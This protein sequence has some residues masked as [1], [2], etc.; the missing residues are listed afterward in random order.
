MRAPGGGVA[1]RISLSH[2]LGV[3]MPPQPA[4]IGRY[5]VLREL[6]RGTMGVVYEA[7]DPILG[8]N[9]ALKVIEIAFGVGEDERHTFERRFFAEARSAARLSHPGIVVVHD[10]GR[11]Q[12]SG[13]LFMALELIEGD[14]VGSVLK[15]RGPFAWQEALRIVARVAE[16]L[17]HAHA[18]GV[19]HRDVKPTNLMLLAPGGEPKVMDFGIAKL[20]TSQ[21]TAA[22]ELLGTPL[23]MSPEQA[24]A[25]PL[26]GRSD[27][28]SLGAVLYEMLTGRRAFAGESVTKIL[29]NVMSLEP[30]APS[31]LATGVP[32]SVDYILARSLSKEAARRYPDGRS[33]AEDIDDVLGGRTPRWRASWP[34]RTGSGTM[35]AAAPSART[36]LAAA[37]GSAHSLPRPPAP[38]GDRIKGLAGRLPRGKRLQAAVGA[39]AVVVLIGG[40]LILRST[41]PSFVARRLEEDSPAAPGGVPDSSPAPSS[42]TG[43]AAESGGMD[44]RSSARLFVDFE[45]SLKGGVLRVWVDDQ[46]IIEEPFGGRITRRIGGIELRKGHLSEGLEVVPG[47]R[48][49]RVQVTWDDNVKT[50][51]TWATF[52]AGDT[53]RLKA[54]LGSLAGLRKD[55]SLDWY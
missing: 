19:V 25:R 46:P 50:E 7:H 8:R 29:F 12:E 6:G 51:R 18:H 17:H 13:A 27:L 34:P 55:L 10:V 24:L 44:S 54:R 49:V 2:N 22:G 15:Q 14:T 1:D 11:D 36:Q 16:A 31:G 32:E 43:S 42:E 37:A 52:K 4:T 9:I 33:L 23:Y 3:T 28:F 47:R 20:E 53:L 30:E 45:H 5:E 41:G 21:L 40:L 26:D 39:V 35:V 38:E 48:E